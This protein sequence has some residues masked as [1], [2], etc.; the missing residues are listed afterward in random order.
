MNLKN[1]NILITAGP[2]REA[3]DPVRFLSNKS[4]GKMAFALAAECLKH[5]AKVLLICGPVSIVAPDGVQIINVISANE[6][7]DA[8]LE[9]IS[10]CDVFIAAAAVSDYR[11]KETFVEKIKKDQNEMTLNFIKNP[12]ILQQVSQLE[13]RLFC[14]GFAAETENLEEN[15]Q[16]K[17][18]K[19][20][21]DLIVANSVSHNKVF[22][23]NKTQAILFGKNGERIA[24]AEMSKNE[25]AEKIITWIA[26]SLRS[27]QRR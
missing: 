23:K 14:V 2:T 18:H 21:L 11:V 8:V 13:Q 27:S 10:A 3:I 6:M 22:D 4:S 5:D 19:K 25:L 9:N 24:L 17:L 12:D 20:K 1:K 15:A 26:S 16:E 7:L